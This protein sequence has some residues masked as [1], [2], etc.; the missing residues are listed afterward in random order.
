MKNMLTINY[1]FFFF[2]CIEANGTING[3]FLIFNLYNR[4]LVTGRSKGK[5]ILLDIFFH[6]FRIEIIIM[7]GTECINYILICEDF[8][9]FNNVLNC[10]VAVI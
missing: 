3:W 7:N 9:H 6:I 8:D 1:G 10:C 5:I 4:S 2:D